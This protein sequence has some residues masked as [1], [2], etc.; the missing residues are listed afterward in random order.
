MFDDPKELATAPLHLVFQLVLQSLEAVI[1][2]LV[3]SAVW[4]WRKLLSDWRY[5]VQLGVF[6][7]GLLAIWMSSHY[8]PGRVWSCFLD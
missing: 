6:A 2:V 8:D 1:P 3:V 4:N 7:I 5:S